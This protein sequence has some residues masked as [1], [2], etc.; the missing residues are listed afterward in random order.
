MWKIALFLASLI[1]AGDANATTRSFFT[2]AFDGVRLSSCLQ[3]GRSCG[4][5]AADAFCQ[6]EGFAE[7]ILFAREQ[8]TAA[9]TL[10]GDGLCEGGTCQAFT[11]IKCYD[12]QVQ[13]ATTP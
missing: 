9:R 7:S 6:K 11:R 13:A 8:V 5:L 10:D 1:T 12:P 2:P 4:K 3:D